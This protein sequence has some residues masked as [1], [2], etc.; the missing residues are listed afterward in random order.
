MLTKI[1]HPDIGSRLALQFLAM[2]LVGLALIHV[3]SDAVEQ[4]SEF[5]Q[6]VNQTGRLR[7]LTRSMAHIAHQYPTNRPV[8]R[9]ELAD[10]QRE[11]EESIVRIEARASLFGPGGL[12][13]FND[14]KRHWSLYRETLSKL[15]QVN[16][17]KQN[18][19]SILLDI[20]IAAEHMLARTEA[21]VASVIEGQAWEKQRLRLKLY[22]ILAFGLAVTAIAYW[23]I[24]DRILRPI[25]RIA[26]MMR[27]FAAGDLDARADYQADDELGELVAVINRTANDTEQLFRRS[28]EAQAELRLRDRAMESTSDGI[29]IT[30]AAGPEYA[31]VYVNPSLCQIVGYER[32]EVLGRNPRF[33]IDDGTHQPEMHALGLL[34][35]EQRD[36]AVVLRINRKDRTSIWV[37]ISVSPMNDDTGQR[38]HNIWVV[39]DVSERKR[40][41]EELIRSAHHDALTGLANRTLFHDRIAQAIA[42]AHRHGRQVGVLFIDLDNFKLVNDSMGHPIGDRLLRETAR[43]LEACLR[44]GDTAS[45]LGGDEFVLL[46]TDMEHEDDIVNIA[47]RV[48][49]AVAQPFHVSGD[50]EIFVG[51]SIG[52][53]IYPRDGE[54]GPTLL[55]HA[56]IAMYRAKEQGRNN[57]QVFTEEMQARITHRLSIETKLRRALER[58]EFTLHYQPQVD[59]VSGRIVSAEALIR[60]QHPEMGLVSPAMFVPLAE[61]TG[62]IVPIGEWVLDAAC[63]QTK[64]WLNAGFNNIS[65]GVNLSARQFRQKNLLQIIEQS[66]RVNQLNSL[67][68]ELELTESMV[69]QDPE[70]TIRILNQLKQLGIRLSLDDFGTGYSS[71]SYLRRFPID[72]LKVDQS[73]IRDVTTNAD[74]ACITSSIISL[75]HGLQLSVIAEGVETREQLRY[76]KQQK[77][78]VMQGYYFSRPLPADQFFALMQADKR[79]SASDLGA[80]S[81]DFRETN[82]L[83]V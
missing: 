47:E 1:L 40:Q 19:E 31:T 4:H 12:A 74:D 51:A 83:N 52:A 42:A 14:M 62:L 8:A 45:R 18:E 57:F 56:D 77:C 15:P 50:G 7:M 28:I 81:T 9:V 38:S 70:V 2:L 67:H 11:M 27:R 17:D 3:A 48:L 68:L 13:V 6:L 10:L 5:A 41:E 23:R 22:T 33:V 66:L 29:M 65:I 44:E 76:L 20:D 39:K 55:K 16:H 46:M 43:R 26:T 80:G 54:D 53:S 78:D 34:L 59:L 75:A 69:M 64:A 25:E 72:V 24:R 37:E 63:T 49:A 61:E 35:R 30:D 60:W 82:L 32:E 21:T 71:L 36:G 58:N 73:F 79:L